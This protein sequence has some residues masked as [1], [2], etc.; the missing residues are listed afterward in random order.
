MNVVERHYVYLR[1]KHKQVPFTGSLPKCPC[2]PGLKPKARKIIVVAEISGLYVL[3]KGNMN[4]KSRVL[5]P[6]ITKM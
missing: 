1:E 3:Q 5:H 4:S 6:P 2:W